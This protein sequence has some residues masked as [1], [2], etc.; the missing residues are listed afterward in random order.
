[1]ELGA[2]LGCR[3]AKERKCIV[4]MPSDSARHPVKCVE[5]CSRSQ[6]TNC[7]SARRLVGDLHRAD[8]CGVV[9]GLYL[10]EVSS[11]NPWRH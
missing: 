11:Y 7:V 10:A 4:P 6:F 2:E 3:T 8:Y 5:C 9:T 1:V